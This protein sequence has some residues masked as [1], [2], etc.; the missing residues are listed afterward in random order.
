MPPASA[1]ERAS[2]LQGGFQELLSRSR[3]LADC[4]DAKILGR[5]AVADATPYLDGQCVTARS[6]KV[7]DAALALDPLSSSGVQKA[8][9][10]S[11]AGAIVINTLLR[12]PASGDAAIRF[13]SDSS[14]RGIRPTRR[15]GGGPLCDRRGGAAGAFW[16]ARADG[17]TRQPGPA[18]PPGAA[19]ETSSG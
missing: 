9:Q 11:L 19:R 12:E 2:L 8:I 18:S 1:P 14:A 4:S 15:L 7:G 5:V 13:Y 3:L 16:S 6:I 17:H 10:T